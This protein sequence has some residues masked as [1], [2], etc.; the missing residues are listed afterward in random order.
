MSD[1]QGSPLTQGREASLTLGLLSLIGNNNHLDLI[2]KQR[3]AFDEA[4]EANKHRHV[5]LQVNLTIRSHVQSKSRIGNN[6]LERSSSEIGAG[7]R[8]PAPLKPSDLSAAHQAGVVRYDVGDDVPGG[9]DWNVATMTCNDNVAWTCVA[10][11]GPIRPV[12]GRFTRLADHLLIRRGRFDEFALLEHHASTDQC[13]QERCVH[14][15][16][17]A[18][19]G[20]DELER[21]TDP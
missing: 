4:R 10:V 12:D 7:F 1:T 3:D 17:A 18:L 15:T 6:V 14:G 21:T 16:P 5:F 19:C 2:G 11:V 9:S 8:S 13:D 20:L